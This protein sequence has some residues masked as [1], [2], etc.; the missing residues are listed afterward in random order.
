MDKVLMIESLNV[1]YTFIECAKKIPD[2][3]KSE[4]RAAAPPY[5]VAALTLTTALY[6]H[7]DAPVGGAR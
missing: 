3:K 7:V 1:A 2:L 6:Y 5:L 4:G